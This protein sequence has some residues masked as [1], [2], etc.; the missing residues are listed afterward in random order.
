M[1]ERVLPRYPVYVLSKSR[2]RTCFTA[3]HLLR[4]RVPFYLVV[5]PAQIDEYREANPTMELLV[6]PRD[7]M[8]A[9]GVRNWIADH[10]TAAGDERHWQL[11]DNMRGFRRLYRGRRIRVNSGIA[12]RVCEDMT[13]RYTNIGVSGLNYTMFVPDTESKPYVVNCHVYSCALIWNRMPYRWRLPLNDDTDLCLQVLAG[14]LCTL[15]LN[16]FS[17]DKI[18]TMKMRGGQGQLY[19][20][21]GR[22]KMAKTLERVWPHVVTTERR[23]DRAQ[24]VIRGGWRGFDTPLIR[25]TDI[26]WDRLPAVDEYGMQVIQVAEEIQSPVVQQIYEHAKTHLSDLSG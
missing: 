25:R 15:Y 8:G 5:E 19:H 21:D 4:D 24:H 17:V 2:P 10:S 16:V 12:L 9:T 22:L 14:G 13:D 7:N 11:D 1:P 18:Q 20:G 26:N 6:A 3:H 23:F